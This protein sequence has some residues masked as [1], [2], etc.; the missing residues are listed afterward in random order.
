MSTHT[1]YIS[2]S[3]YDSFI[4]CILFWIL[5]LP[6]RGSFLVI[7]KTDTIILYASHS[8]HGLGGFFIFLLIPEMILPSNVLNNKKIWL[9]LEK[10]IVDTQGNPVFAIEWK[11][12]YE[13]LATILSVEMKKYGFAITCEVFRHQIEL[14]L[15][16]P[17]IQEEAIESMQEWYRCVEDY[18]KKQWLFLASQA[19]PLPYPCPWGGLEVILTP[20]DFYKES[21]TKVNDAWLRLQKEWILHY[22]TPKE[23]YHDAITQIGTKANNFSVARNAST[24]ALH[25]HTS[26]ACDDLTLQLVWVLKLFESYQIVD[27]WENWYEIFGMGKNRYDAWKTIVDIRNS[28]NETLFPFGMS[29]FDL[30]QGNAWWLTVPHPDKWEEDMKTWYFG[31]K[32]IPSKE[33]N[34]P[35]DHQFAVLKA[36]WDCFTAELRGHD[37]PNNPDDIAIMVQKNNDILQQAV[38]LVYTK[39]YSLW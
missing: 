10:C 33:R 28:L 22:V 19:H 38:E 26:L 36:P 23:P 30:W 11:L 6:V 34:V 17:M 9:E 14:V 1:L 13:Y 29:L 4:C 7:T 5:L 39:V 24:C 27:W 32:Q 12:P 15:S 21:M 37:A 35:R 2:F 3:P 31:G 20:F 18:L 25:Q 16:W 8:I